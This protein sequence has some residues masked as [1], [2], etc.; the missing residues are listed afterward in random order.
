MLSRSMPRKTDT[1]AEEAAHWQAFRNYLDNIDKYT[2]VEAQKDDL[3]PLAALRHRLWLGQG[4]HPQVRARGCARARLVHPVA[5]PVR[6]LSPLVLRD[7]RRRASR[8][9]AA[10][11]A[12]GQHAVRRQSRRQLE[13]YEPRHGFGPVRHERGFRRHAHRGQLDLHQPARQL[14]IG[15]RLERR[16]RLQR[17][18]WRWWRRRWWRRWRLRLNVAI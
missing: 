15:R 3:G 10:G 1:G 9:L 11:P 17:R 8:R 6:A 7:V 2:D 13:R 18:R 4:V 12:G 16:R 5:H 14:V